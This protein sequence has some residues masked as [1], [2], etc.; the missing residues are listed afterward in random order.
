MSKLELAAAMRNGS[1]LARFTESE[2]LAVIE[3]LERLGFSH[4]AM[5]DKAA[6]PAPV[7]AAPPAPVPPAP[8][9]TA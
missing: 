4:P 6:A 2:I 5:T 7:V 8:A 3:H 1:A 9:A